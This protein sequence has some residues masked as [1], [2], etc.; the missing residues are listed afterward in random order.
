MKVVYAKASSQ[1]FRDGLAVTVTVGQHWPAND[2]IVKE[3][4]DWF[5]TDARFGLTSS[6][7][8]SETDDEPE[9][10]HTPQRPPSGQA[11]EQT[12][13]APDEKRLSTRRG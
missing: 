5:T 8:P 1:L 4:P 11:V 9:G 12:T 6:V 10:E 13:A 7:A 3:Y 2:P